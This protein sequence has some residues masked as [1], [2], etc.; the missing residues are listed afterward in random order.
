V[1]I[2]VGG[3]TSFTVT[4]AV[5]VDEFP[6]TSVTV[7]VT[8]FAPVLAQVNEE[9]ETD[10]EAIPHASVEPLFT[11]AAVIVAFPDEFKSTDIFWQIAVGGVTSTT[12]TVAVQ[13]EVFPFTSVTVKVTVLAPTLAQ[14]NELGDTLML[15]IPQ[16]SELPLFTCAA[17][18]ETVPAAFRFTVIF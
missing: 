7:S 6:F 3:V 14:V 9:G 17:V 4:V 11:C 1:Q 5:Q 10:S 8:V 18:M 2:A 13:V 12:V 15:A 16:A